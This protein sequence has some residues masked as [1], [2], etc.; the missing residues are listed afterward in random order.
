MTTMAK[1][2]GSLIA[3]TP[4]VAARPSGTGIV[5]ML[6]MRY[7]TAALLA[8]LLMAAGGLGIYFVLRILAP[9]GLALWAGK[10][11][12]PPVIVEVGAAFPGAT[13]QTF[14]IPGSAASPL[15][16]SVGCICSLSGTPITTPPDRK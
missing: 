1:V 5:R 8:F 9:G 11:G 15:P 3:Y 13:A 12:N 4:F 14:V 7:R 2:A 10:R 16:A 6:Q